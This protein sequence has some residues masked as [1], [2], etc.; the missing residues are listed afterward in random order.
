MPSWTHCSVA[1]ASMPRKILRTKPRRARKVLHNNRLL[2]AETS[3]RIRKRKRNRKL[4]KMLSKMKK[5]RRIK[6]SLWMRRPPQKLP[7]P[8]SNKKQKRVVNQ[9]IIGPILLPRLKQKRKREVPRRIKST[10]RRNCIE[11]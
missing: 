1:W 9:I 5:K 2:M 6:R 4:K 8:R 7:S 3:L 10:E 11:C